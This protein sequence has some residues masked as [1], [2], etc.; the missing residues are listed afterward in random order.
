MIPHTICPMAV[1]S[2]HKLKTLG[3]DNVK[4]NCNRSGTFVNNGQLTGEYIL[5]SNGIINIIDEIL[6]PDSGEQVI[7]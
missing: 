6:I 1:T 5:S 7:E 4:L 3:G 2:Q